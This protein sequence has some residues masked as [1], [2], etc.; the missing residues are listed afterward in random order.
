VLGK[1]GNM[2]SSTYYIRILCV[3]PRQQTACSRC[4]TRLGTAHRIGLC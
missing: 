4:Q 1:R 2:C 3:D